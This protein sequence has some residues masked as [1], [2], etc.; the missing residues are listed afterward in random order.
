M[1]GRLSRQGCKKEFLTHSNC[2][3]GTR[4]T[5]L[6]WGRSCSPGFRLPCF[7]CS[8]AMCWRSARHRHR[9]RPPAVL[10]QA[11]QAAEL[12]APCAMVKPIEV[13]AM[14]SKPP[15]GVGRSNGHPRPS[16]LLPQIG[17]QCRQDVFFMDAPANSS[18]DI[19]KF[20]I[21]LR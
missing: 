16:N 3:R 4:C 6:T 20:S 5:L 8:G 18:H 2:G 12:K 9:S 10:A 11:I 7:P 14:L 15:V 19:A 1:V 21:P 17:Q 13:A